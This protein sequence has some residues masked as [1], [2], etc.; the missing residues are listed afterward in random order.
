MSPGAPCS[1]AA[2]QVAPAVG[3]EAE[4]AEAEDHH[5]PGGRLGTAA[6]TPAPGRG[7]RQQ[8]VFDFDVP[9]SGFRTTSQSQ[10]HIGGIVEFRSTPSTG[11]A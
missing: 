10:C 2:S 9:L 7:Y 1:Q 5:R 6:T 8:E 3:E 4:R 11:S